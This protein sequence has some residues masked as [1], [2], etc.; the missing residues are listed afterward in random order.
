MTSSIFVC[1]RS[2]LSCLV[3]PLD[4]WLDGVVHSRGVQVHVCRMGGKQS[5]L[6]KSH[7]TPGAVSI[8]VPHVSAVGPAGGARP[9]V[10]ALAE[11]GVH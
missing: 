10:S 9:S 5:V 7:P 2:A 11:E 1:S 8:P 3:F 4:L 6:T